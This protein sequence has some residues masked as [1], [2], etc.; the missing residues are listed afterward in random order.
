MTALGFVMSADRTESPSLGALR[1]GAH[2]AGAHRLRARA[3]GRRNFAVTVVAQD[4]P[5]AHGNYATQFLARGFPLALAARDLAADIYESPYNQWRAE[6]LDPAF[7]ASCVRAHSHRPGAHFDRACIRS[8][9]RRRCDRRSVV[10]AVEAALKTSEAYFLVTLPEPLADEVCDDSAAYGWRR[11]SATAARGADL[12]AGHAYR[13]RTLLRITGAQAWFDDRFYDTA[14]IPFLPDRTPALLGVF[15]DAVV[16]AFAP[17]CKLVI[18]DLDN[19][20]WGGVVGDDGY[21]GV[22]LD[23]AGKGRHFLRL[24]SFL[25]GLRAK[26]ILLAIASKNEPPP[27]RK[28]SPSVA[29]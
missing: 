18:V 5:G 29:R 26:G 3:R 14:K 25:A 12:A 8:A 7:A 23:P 20:L 27:S 19:T 2:I 1:R 11:R 4:A 10:A 9:A 28:C 15:A 16:G 24:Q 6:L 21:A 22:D 17:R 13:S